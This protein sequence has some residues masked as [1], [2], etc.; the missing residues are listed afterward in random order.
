MTNMLCKVRPNNGSESLSLQAR[1]LKRLKY[2]IL[3]IEIEG[4]SLFLG[5]LLRKIYSKTVYLGLEKKL[6]SECASVPCQIDYSLR[7]ATKEDMREIVEKAR[8]E[9]RKS[10]YELF[11][12]RLFYEAG[13]RNCYVAID[14]AT[15]EICHMQWLLSSK[16]MPKNNSYAKSLPRLSDET[17][18]IENT[19]TFCKYRGKGLYP[20]V[21]VRLAE[22]ARDSG[23]NQMKIYVQQDNAASLRGCQKAGFRVFEQ[24]PEMKLLFLTRRKYAQI[25]STAQNGRFTDV[26]Y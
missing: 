13:F 18:L 19:F 24:V 20:S 2:A 8:K 16:D 10:A 21:M 1:A 4:P 9:D 6:N 3:L 7:L 25:S 12:R 15:G 26:V 5:R 23:F 14:I 17:I 11:G 22:M